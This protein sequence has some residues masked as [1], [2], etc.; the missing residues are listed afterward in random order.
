MRLEGCLP[1]EPGRPRDDILD[2]ER[3]ALIVDYH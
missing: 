1:G 2:I 3:P